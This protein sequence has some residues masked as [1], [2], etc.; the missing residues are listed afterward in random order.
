VD[1]LCDPAAPASV[2]LAASD[3]GELMDIT[4]AEPTAD[5]V[6]VVRLSGELGV[7]TVQALQEA[8]TNLVDQRAH[9]V[10]VDLSDLGFCDSIGL[11]SFVEAHRRGTAAGGWVRLAAPSPF[12][13]R[14]LGVVGLLGRLPVYA[15]VAGAA[16]DDRADRYPAPDASA[17]PRR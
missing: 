13:L 10:V 4:V 17:G 16:A 5:G 2:R 11:S 14:V 8:L 6:T 7:D 3:E 15:T 9:R 1:R 12:L